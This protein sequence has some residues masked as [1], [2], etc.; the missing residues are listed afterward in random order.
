M[1]YDPERRARALA[2]LRRR[3]IV[4]EASLTPTE[5]L[6]QAEELLAVAWSLHGPPAE[7]PWSML[8]ARRARRG[9]PR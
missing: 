7:E 5:R 2:E 6:E 9:V 1:F 8:A 3:Q 4:D